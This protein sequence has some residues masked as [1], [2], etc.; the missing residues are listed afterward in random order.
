MKYVFRGVARLHDGSKNKYDIND[1]AT[2]R[3][4][5]DALALSAN[6]KTVLVLVQPLRELPD[7]N[8]NSPKAA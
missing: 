3:E 8:A 5:W 1:C 7:E 4:A 2:W 6:V